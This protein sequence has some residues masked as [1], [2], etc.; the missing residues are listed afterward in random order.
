MSH[1]RKLG[2]SGLLIA[3]ALLVALIAPAG[4]LAQVGEPVPGAEVFLQQQPGDDPIQNPDPGPE[5]D[6]FYWLG[7]EH[8]VNADCT[9]AWP[10]GAVPVGTNMTVMVGFSEVGERATANGLVK[11]V[12]LLRPPGL[13]FPAGKE[14]TLVLACP[15]GLSNPRMYL[16]DPGSGAWNLVSSTKNGDRLSAQIPHYSIYGVGGDPVVTS[17]PASSDWSLAL[18]IVGALGVAFMIRLRRASAKV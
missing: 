18:A 2:I 14:L 10:G 3:V 4:A 12:A 13:T 11:R 8:L 6:P 15:P 5:P 1:P 9:I 7:G 16:K 17:T